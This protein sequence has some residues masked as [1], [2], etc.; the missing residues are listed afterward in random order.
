V[1]VVKTFN[2]SPRWSGEHADRIAGLTII[3]LVVSPVEPKL[4]RQ[5]KVHS[6]RIL[7][8]AG[9]GSVL[10]EEI[11]IPTTDSPVIEVGQGEN[12]QELRPKIAPQALGDYVPGNLVLVPGMMTGMRTPPVVTL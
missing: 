7:I 11:V 8:S 4:L 1:A 9:D 10:V 12:I 2:Q 3:D 6:V 5:V